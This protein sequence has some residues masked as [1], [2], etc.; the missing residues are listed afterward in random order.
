ML[1][2]TAAVSSNQGRD[3]SASGR[4]VFSD[5]IRS[6]GRDDTLRRYVERGEW[7]VGKV[8]HLLSLVSAG[9]GAGRGLL[10]CPHRT[11]IFT[12]TRA[13]T[14]AHTQTSKERHTY[15]NTQTHTHIHTQINKQTSKKESET[16]PF[17]SV[18]STLTSMPHS[19]NDFC[20]KPH[21]P[22]MV[23]VRTY[24][25][26]VRFQQTCHLSLTHVHHMPTAPPRTCP[27]FP[28]VSR[29]MFQC[30]HLA[31]QVSS[32]GQSVC[33]PRQEWGS[34]IRFVILAKG[35]TMLSLI[36]I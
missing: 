5:P 28:V 1:R 32:A 33:C 27:S 34:R 8:C 6:V 3:A 29:V 18:G 20:C 21:R 31:H 4:E 35:V 15:A 19:D 11:Q 7:R 10:I 24:C 12:Q 25:L 13:Q 30:W 9:L 14:H 23:S 16:G 36:H 2:G 17:C 26:G 22:N